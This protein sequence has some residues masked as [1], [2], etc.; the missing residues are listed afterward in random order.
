MAFVGLSVLSAQA[1]G[2][3]DFAAEVGRQS[4]PGRRAIRGRLV[5]SMRRPA[6][7]D[8]GEMVSHHHQR[9]QVGWIHSK[10][11]IERATLAQVISKSATG[12][13]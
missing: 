10:Q 6:I 2:T 4:F 5:K 1:L 7:A 12:E 9:G 8:F 3:A 13:R 11:A